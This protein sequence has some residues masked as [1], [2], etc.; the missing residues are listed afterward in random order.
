MRSFFPEMTAGRQPF[1]GH[2]NYSIACPA[3]CRAG[4]FM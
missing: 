2:F 4:F 1:G 3:A